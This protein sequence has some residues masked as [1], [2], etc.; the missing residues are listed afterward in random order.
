MAQ[1]IQWLLAPIP[2]FKKTRPDLT[3]VLICALRGLERINGLVRDGQYLFTTQDFFLIV[4]IIIILLLFIIISIPMT[5][6]VVV[7]ASPRGLN[8]FNRLVNDTEND[9][10]DFLFTSPSIIFLKKHLITAF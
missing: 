5:M 3:E 10:K 2:D 1:T 9:E 7:F 8:R 4:V 6:V